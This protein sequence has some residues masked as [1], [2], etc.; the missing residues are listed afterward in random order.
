MMADYPVCL[1][2]INN[3]PKAGFISVFSLLTY[4]PIGI[5]LPANDALFVNWTSNFL[6]RMDRTLTLDVL[7]KKWLGE[8]IKN[9]ENTR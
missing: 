1:Y 6:E 7:A 4:E 3:N 2:T 9:A 5:A 8:L